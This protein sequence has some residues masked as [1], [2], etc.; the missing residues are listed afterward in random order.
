MPEILLKHKLETLA[1]PF[2]I[3]TKT[4]TEDAAQYTFEGYA[5]TYGNVDRGGD[6]VEPGAFKKT[7]N[8]HKDVGWPLIGMHDMSIILGGI[9]PLGDDSKGFYVKGFLVK[10]VQRA[11]EY[12]ALMQPTPDFPKGIVNAMSIG[13]RSIKNTIK[14]NMRHL[15][16]IAVHEITLAPWS[17][18]MNQKAIVTEVKTDTELYK[19]LI[20][21]NVVFRTGI[22]AGGTA[23][24]DSV[25][26]A[27][28][29]WQKL[30]TEIR[31]GI[32]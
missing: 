29:S 10:A 13:Y 15:K 12:Y 24:T 19:E 30:L 18:V 21:L 14:N 23:P 11:Q 3:E 20:A 17:F 4:L 9:K 2:E 7:I 27:L 8:D 1:C 32:N 5:S 31:G 25:A 22:P 26:D 6:V 16:E 28:Q